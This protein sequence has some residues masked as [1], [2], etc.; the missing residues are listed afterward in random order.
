[1]PQG[2]K[3]K[4]TGKQQRKAGSGRSAADRSVAAKKGWEARRRQ[5][6]A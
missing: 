5:G 2:D 3:D 1:M 4:Y 6:N